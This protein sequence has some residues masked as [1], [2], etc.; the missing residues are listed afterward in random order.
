VLA[1]KRQGTSVADN[2]EAR[3]LIILRERQ[4]KGPLARVDNPR[5]RELWG[6]AAGIDRLVYRW[7]NAQRISR[8]I[9]EAAEASH[10]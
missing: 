4:L 1:L 6:G 2:R 3:N 10:A 5:A 8:D 7:P 9:L